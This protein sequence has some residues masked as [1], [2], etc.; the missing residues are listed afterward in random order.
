MLRPSLSEEEFV[1]CKE[2]IFY[3][4]FPLIYRNTGLFTPRRDKFLGVTT[5]IL[6]V[7]G[8]LMTTNFSFHI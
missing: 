1:I 2:H 8:A 6:Q 5:F 7:Y 3:D 4:Y